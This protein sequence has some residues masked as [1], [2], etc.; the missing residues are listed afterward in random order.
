MSQVTHLFPDWEE[1][2]YTASL[3]HHPPAS[4]LA[5]V[6]AT[7]GPRLPAPVLLLLIK[8]HPRM[9]HGRPRC[10]LSH[11]PEGSLLPPKLCPPGAQVRT[12]SRASVPWVTWVIRSDPG[13]RPPLVTLARAGLALAMQ[14]S[15]PEATRL[16][17]TAGRG[18]REEGSP[19]ARG[20]LWLRHRLI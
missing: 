3:P 5:A 7:R 8:L 9:T 10:V 13:D 2:V 6:R 12:D 19:G 4:L 17:P 18:V 15:S 16:W 14:L 1:R 11:L 20:V